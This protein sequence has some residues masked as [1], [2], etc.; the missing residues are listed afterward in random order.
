[1]ATEL[2]QNNPHVLIGINPETVDNTDILLLMMVVVA[3]HHGKK[4]LVFRKSRSRFFEK[5]ALTQSLHLEASHNIVFIDYFNRESM[6]CTF[7]KPRMIGNP[8]QELTI[9][10]NDINAQSA[11]SEI[12]T[13]FDRLNHILNNTPLRLLADDLAKI[14]V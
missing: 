1:M 8:R 13:Q 7:L 14:M 10:L 2:A 4:S 6:L 9:S 3:F 5:D 11:I 12:R